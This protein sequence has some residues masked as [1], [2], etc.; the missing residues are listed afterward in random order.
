MEI[1]YVKVCYSEYPFL[2]DVEFVPLEHFSR[3]K[4]NNFFLLF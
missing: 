1:V 3:V 4:Y 2:F